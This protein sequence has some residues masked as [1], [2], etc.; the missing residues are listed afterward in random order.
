MS[1]REQTIKNVDE[2]GGIVVW[3]IPKTST[4]PWKEARADV[5]LTQEGVDVYLKRGLIVKMNDDDQS[6]LYKPVSDFLWTEELQ[7]IEK[8]VFA[9]E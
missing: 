2:F 4:S 1:F 3:T 9:N 6:K 8:E 5:H 7:S